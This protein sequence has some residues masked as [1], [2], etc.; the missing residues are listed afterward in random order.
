MGGTQRRDLRRGK[1][2]RV[3]DVDNRHFRAMPRG[4]LGSGVALRGEQAT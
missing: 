3:A 4:Q 1:G 2:P